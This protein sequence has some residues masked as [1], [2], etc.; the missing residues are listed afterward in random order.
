MHSTDKINTAYA[1]AQA[2]EEALLRRATE[3][4]QKYQLELDQDSSTLLAF[5]A[6]GAVFKNPEKI[7]TKDWAISM[8]LQEWQHC[9]NSAI[10]QRAFEF[11]CNLMGHTGGNA[12]KDKAIMDVAF[13]AANGK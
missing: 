2:K 11:A 10:R 6:K 8:A 1:E 9:D 3:L 12:L 5:L 13:E 4:C 7:F